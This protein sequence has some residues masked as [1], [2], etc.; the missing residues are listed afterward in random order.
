MKRLVIYSQDGMGLGHLRRTR[1]I[2]REVLAW[3]PDCSI[4]IIA[5]SPAT[6][7][8]HPPIQGVD[9]VKLP[10]IVKISDHTWKPATLPLKIKET[11]RLRS[12]LILHTLHEFQPDAV[13]VDHMP[14]GAL[15]ELKS[16]LDK[17]SL[18]NNRPRF[19]LGLRDILGT[20]EV[21]R[22]AWQSVGA[23]DYLSAY[24]RV[25]I[26]GC[27]EIYPVEQAY[28]LDPFIE[29][30]RYCNYVAPKQKGLD[31]STSGE[32]GPPEDPYILL[33]GGGGKD[34]F[35]LA[36]L[37]LSVAPTIHGET[38]LGA[39][40]LTGPNMTAKDQAQLRKRARGKEVQIHTTTE[41][42]S[43]WIAKSSAVLTMAGYNSLCET[44]S[45]KKKALVVP[46]SGPSKEQRIRTEILARRGV[47]RMID[48]DHITEK[49]LLR[50]LIRLDREDDV[51]NR[52]NIPPLDG[53][54][55]AAALLQEFPVG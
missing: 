3:N 5:D 28:Q 11:M 24:D 20:P 25:F 34:L 6:P 13:L 50:E 21:I 29:K 16:I 39:V 23:Y 41:G 12:R 53:A 54:T 38:K 36:N 31:S 30:I 1:S 44:L 46:R 10:T 7:F 22:K 8:F 51:P 45:W 9:Y 55:R 40:I 47:V 49:N 33:M 17:N 37:F 27:Q 43:R 14:V 2:A 35:P 19:Y 26:Y 48:P 15:G 4:L 42:A 32:I 18:G 52:A